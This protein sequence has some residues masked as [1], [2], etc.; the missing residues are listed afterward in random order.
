MQKSIQIRWLIRRDLPEVLAFDTDPLWPVWDEEEHLKHL[1]QR[2]CIGLVAEDGK[3]VTGYVLYLLKPRSLEVVR[4]ASKAGEDAARTA[5]LSRLRSKL[6]FERR[7]IM[8][9]LFSELDLKTLQAWRNVGGI[10]SLQRGAFGERD[11]IEMSV[12]VEAPIMEGKWHPAN[13]VSGIY[14]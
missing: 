6:S 3:E 1:R 11:G 4:L 13:R 10:A 5:L 8:Q 9:G 7:P 2:N 14:E 12:S